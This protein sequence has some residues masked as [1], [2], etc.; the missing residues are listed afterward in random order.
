MRYLI[1]SDLHANLEAVSRVIEDARARGFD[2][3]AVLGDIVGYGAN[4]NEVIDLVRE[5]RPDAMVRGNHDKAACG[6]T[7]GE[8]F[9][10]VARTAVL[11]TRRALSPANLEYLKSLPAGPVDP[12]GFLIAHGS[13]LDEED[14]ILGELDASGA[15]DNVDF[16][17]AFFGHSHFACY[18]MSSGGRPRLRMVG[19]DEHLMKLE[20][21]ARYLINSGSI[22]QPRDHNPKASYAIFD[23]EA[24][25]VEVRRVAYD[26]KGA[27]ARIEAAGLPAVLAQ[28]LALGV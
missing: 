28:R 24:R 27:Q 4:P 19:G 21:G 17:L 6:I 8:T 22:G 3:V 15:L 18:F 10:D 16:E 1:L 13:P 2:R 25:T 23:A 7:N 11:W 5:L 9:N 26:V 14:Y 12:G 20:P